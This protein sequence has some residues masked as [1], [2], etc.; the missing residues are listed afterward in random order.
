M[1]DLAWLDVLCVPQIT[2]EKNDAEHSREIGNQ[3]E[4]YRTVA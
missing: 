1:L 3:G 2:N 4:I